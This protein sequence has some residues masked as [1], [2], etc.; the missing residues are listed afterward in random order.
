MAVF[1]MAKH[2]GAQACLLKQRI[3]P[4]DLDTTIQQTI[5]AVK[6]KELDARGR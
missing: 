2:N 4:K 6:S 5:A 3:S 1:E